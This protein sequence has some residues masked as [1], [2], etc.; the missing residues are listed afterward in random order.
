MWEYPLAA[1]PQAGSCEGDN[2][3]SSFGIQ[4][5]H[6]PRCLIIKLV[7]AAGRRSSAPLCSVFKT[8]RR[9]VGQLKTQSDFS[10]AYMYAYHFSHMHTMWFPMT[11]DKASKALTRSLR[12]DVVTYSGVNMR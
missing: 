6:L 5:N 10:Y 1:R 9:L 7:R 11:I 8:D 4:P 2:H 3:E 12:E